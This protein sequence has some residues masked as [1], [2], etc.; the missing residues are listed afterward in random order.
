[1]TDNYGVFGRLGHQADQELI[2]LLEAF[3]PGVHELD[4]LAPA[5][6]GVRQ[7]GSIGLRRA[8]GMQADAVTRCQLGMEKGVADERDL[9]GRSS[10]CKG[11]AGA[12]CSDV[13]P[14]V[15]GGR[16]SQVHA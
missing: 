14:I 16:I 3:Q 8:Q 12:S 11:R 2:V 4:W 5:F 13:L 9:L 6:L 15:P 1:M 10:S 7:R